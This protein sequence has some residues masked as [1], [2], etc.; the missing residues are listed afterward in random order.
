MSILRII[1]GTAKVL[2]KA[3]VVVDLVKVLYKSVK[4]IIKSESTDGDK[5][6]KDDKDKKSDSINES[7]KKNDDK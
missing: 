7:V 3:V 2:S 5:D 4:S 1:T 6:D